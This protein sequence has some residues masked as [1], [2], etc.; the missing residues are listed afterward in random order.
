MATG[1]IFAVPLFGQHAVCFKIH[2][3]SARL[4]TTE[5]GPTLITDVFPFWGIVGNV[6]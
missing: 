6:V 1:A 5:V 3:W 2:G 4:L